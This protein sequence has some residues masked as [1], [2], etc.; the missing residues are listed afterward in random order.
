M[1]TFVK[2]CKSNDNTLS[3]KIST[4]EQTLEI[5]TQDI[6]EGVRPT[7]K[8]AK[9][10]SNHQNQNINSNEKPGEKLTIASRNTEIQPVENYPELSVTSTQNPVV[11]NQG[12]VGSIVSPSQNLIVENPIIIAPENQTGVIETPHIEETAKAVPDN[13]KC[14][15]G[16]E[17]APV[18]IK[19]GSEESA[20]GWIECEVCEQWWH[21]HCAGLIQKTGEAASSNT[22]KCSFCILKEVESLKLSLNNL[23][24]NSCL[25]FDSKTK[26]NTYKVKKRSERT[27]IETRV[28]PSKERKYIVIV[29]GV[30]KK[31]NSSVLI[32]EEIAKFY[33]EIT[34]KHCYQLVRGGIAI[35][36]EDKESEEIL[37]KPWPTGA[38]G[39][40]KKLISH[41]PSS[42]NKKSIVIKQV[43][44][45]IEHKEICEYLKTT[46]K[47]TDIITRRFYKNRNPLP[48]VKV[49]ASVNL[50][51]QWINQEIQ[52]F[53]QTKP[54]EAYKFRYIPTRC[55]RCQ[56]FGHTAKIC[57]G[58]LRCAK[59]GKEHLTQDCEETTHH[60][61]NC[62]GDHPAYD[63]HCPSFITRQKKGAERRK[64]TQIA[65]QIDDQ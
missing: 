17:N 48:I 3:E 13:E 62:K 14:P 46:Y 22:F 60:C 35:H 20:G 18:I 45:Q 31:F 63:S 7:R 50:V 59:C 30:T 5:N 25:N 49:T 55:Y 32:K 19:E 40:D 65:Q 42:T 29:D 21:E 8:C 56:R 51:N 38:F 28:P 16:N 54:C 58:L 9:R 41:R 39:T 47:E 64:K 1:A 26:N 2:T 15:C 43:E 36:V 6:I 44:S 53:G 23:K 24:K 33:K 27:Y 10:L 37:L 4:E 57:F 11:T 52:V 12:E 61:V 34:I